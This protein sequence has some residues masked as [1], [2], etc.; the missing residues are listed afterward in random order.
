MRIDPVTL[1]RWGEE[2]ACSLLRLKGCKIVARNYRVGKYELDIVAL[3]GSEIVFVEV[4]TRRG[5]EHGEPV[6]AVGH[7]KQR[8]LSRAA[9]AFVADKRPNVRSSR[10]DVIGVV[11]DEAGVGVSMRHIIGAFECADS[12]LFV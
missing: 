10:F 5:V 3:D 9:A 8:D 11:L 2:I 1:G 6:G 4:K 12:D 7:K